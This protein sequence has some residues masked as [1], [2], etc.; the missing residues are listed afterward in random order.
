MA[1]DK[2]KSFPKIP[3]ANWFALRERF[4]QK[5]PT[6]ITVSY[7]ATA[8]DINQPS[9]ANL[10]APLKQLGLVGSDNRLTDLAFEWR[11]DAT[12]AAACQKMLEATYPT[13]LR[14]LFH[15]SSATPQG[16]ANWISTHTRLGQSVSSAMASLYLLLLEADPSKEVTPKAKGS[17]STVKPL[18]QIKPLKVAA[19]P[20]APPPAENAGKGDTSDSDEDKGRARGFSPKLH[21]DI[22]IHISPDSTP[23]QID[24][25][26]ESMAKHLPLKG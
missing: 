17:P 25:I 26:F 6:E 3:R 16:V 11:N 1:E 14:E 15:D 21:V 18:K 24:K 20:A 7:L 22:Q 4:K 8:L 13:E 19:K 10:L 12:Y 9:A 2:K 23:E 5:P